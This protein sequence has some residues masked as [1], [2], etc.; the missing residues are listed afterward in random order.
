MQTAV[1]GLSRR[2]KCIGFVPTMGALH[3][4]HLSLIRRCRKENDVCVVSIFVNP[5]QFGPQEDYQRYPRDIRRDRRLL[6]KEGVDILFLPEARAMFPKPFRTWITVEKLSDGL[7]GRFRPGHF[8]GVTTV[9]TKLL[10]IVRPD[11]LYLGQKDAQ[12]AAVI[13]TM[14]ADLNFPLKVSVLPTV[15]EPDGLAMSS[16]N[17]YLSGAGRRRALLL[18][19]SLKHARRRVREGL[20]ETH[21]LKNEMR[22]IIRRGHPDTVEYIVFADP[23]SLKPVSKLAGKTLIALAVR[24][25]RIRLIDNTIVNAR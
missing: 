19:Q 17:R 8:R 9:V 18:S 2:N 6:K 22:A 1:R 4:G 16:R 25:G 21:R 14:V 13:K 5:T 10:H 7:C 11:S 12:Q 24:F 23:N 15:R 20:R 3:D